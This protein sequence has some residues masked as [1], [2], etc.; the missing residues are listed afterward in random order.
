MTTRLHNTLL[1]LFLAAMGGCA[2]FD[3]CRSGAGKCVSDH[4]QGSCAPLPHAE[5]TIDPVDQMMPVPTNLPQLPTAPRPPKLSR[6]SEVPHRPMANGPV[7]SGPMP[8]GPMPY[9]PMPGGPMPPPS[10]ALRVPWQSVP[11][12]LASQASNT[13]PSVAPPPTAQT[14]SLA[15]R[16]APVAP[17]FLPVSTTVGPTTPTTVAP[18]VPS[19]RPAPAPTPPSTPTVATS[20]TASIKAAQAVAAPRPASSDEPIIVHELPERA[21]PF[22][23]VV[24]SQPMPTATATPTPAAP[25]SAAANT[26][27]AKTTTTTAVAPPPKVAVPEIPAIPPLAS[28]STSPAPATAV[29]SR[30]VTATPPVAASTRV[31]VV[32]SVELPPPPPLVSN[33]PPSLPATPPLL[34]GRPVPTP[35]RMPST[36]A[37]PLGTAEP[38]ADQPV[39][40]RPFPAVQH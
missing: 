12:P 7:P 34:D 24:A 35:V 33:G 20:Q 14:Y 22:V 1:A 27:A 8:S 28:V 18:P 32:P 3:N 9:G 19:A 2:R 26:T 5:P 15:G 38:F 37:M 6:G 31:P 10:E 21:L 23:P 39:A 40:A 16:P 4:Q 29:A 13:S 30:P 36:S 17:V 25:N 11:G